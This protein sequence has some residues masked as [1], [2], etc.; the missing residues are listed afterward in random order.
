MDNIGMAI[1]IFLAIGTPILA[2]YTIVY[3]CAA[4][5]ISELQ[6]HLKCVE[7]LRERVALINGEEETLEMLDEAIEQIEEQLE[8]HW[9]RKIV[10]EKKENSYSKEIW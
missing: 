2:L 1:L 8:T 5:S 7:N 10:K 4:D 9:G 6:H 3:K